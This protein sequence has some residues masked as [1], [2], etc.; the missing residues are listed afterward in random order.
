MAEIASLVQVL[1]VVVGVVIS[2]RSFNYTR[3]KEA[4]AR[5]IEAAKPFLEL[6]QRVYLEAVK[7]AGILA[8]PDNHSEEEITT[9]K[10][11][12]RE[13]YVTELS[14]VEAPEVMHE[15]VE[16]ARQIDP[17][18]PNFTPAQ[19]AAYRL[20]HALRDSFVASWEGKELEPIGIIEALRRGGTWLSGR[21]G[22]SLTAPPGGS[23]PPNT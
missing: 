15:M 10:K 5:R 11:R 4:D 8:N 6:R 20:S 14:M 17:E 3:Q 9:A 1:S 18:L 23:A 21:L 22:W 16:L 19:R 2:I 13:L 7:V 12:F